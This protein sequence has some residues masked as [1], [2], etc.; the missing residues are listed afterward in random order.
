MT[1]DVLYLDI[2]GGRGGSSRSLRFLIEHL[3]KEAYRPFVALRESGTSAAA[4]DAAGVGHAIIPD[5]PAFR[6]GSRRNWVS[7]LLYRLADAR[8]GKTRAK[9]GRII[10]E[11]QVRLVHVNHEGLALLGSELARE[12]GIPWICHLRNTYP[13]NAW[14]RWL[15]RQ[16]ATADGHVYISENERSHI[17]ALAELVAPPPNG[18]VVY[19]FAPDLERPT[20]PDPR[21]LDAGDKLK[22]I[23]LA[24]LSPERGVDRVVDVA[25]ALKRRG[26]QDFVFFVCGK[27]SRAARPW[28]KSFAKMLVERIA[29]ENL[30]D[31]VR[32]VGH[33]AEPERA[34]V[35]SDVLFRP[36]RQ[37]NPW[38]R[39]VIEGMSAGMP[40]VA[41]GDY[42]GFVEHGRGGF[43][44]PD[45]DADQI[46]DHLV[47]LRDDP[48]LRQQMGDHNRTKARG[49]FSGADNVSAI[50]ALYRK[51]F[52][53]QP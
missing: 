52:D 20:E 37:S 28:R 10:R 46:A 5:M 40:V 51:I 47:R 23:I 22:I 16:I 19:N 24:N 21:F 33:V 42:E 34:L 36:R 45:F 50:H 14:S 1:T 15:Y 38:G 35:A 3:D 12:A 2:E 41:M 13:D 25:A 26:R 17:V 49:L 4:Y 11:R 32:F 30:G 39:D 48:E 29:A 7:W 27:D 31:L 53:G 6:P 44:E 8:A 43:I 9:L 18:I